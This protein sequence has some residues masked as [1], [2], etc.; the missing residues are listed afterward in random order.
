MQARAAS[1]KIRCKYAIINDSNGVK[2]MSIETGFIIGALFFLC[3]WLAGKD[4]DHLD[5]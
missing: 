4:L 3:L 5:P 2:K 1:F